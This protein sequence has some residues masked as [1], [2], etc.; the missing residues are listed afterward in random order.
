MNVTAATTAVQQ[1]GFDYLSPERVL[2]M[3]N[4]A[5]DTFE[6]QYE[7]PWLQT[8]I[9][10]P[11]P[12]TV[13]DLKLVQNVRCGDNELMGLSR[14]QVLQGFT[15]LGHA[16]TPEYWWIEG[17]DIVHAWPGDGAELAIVY[18]ADSPELIT[19]TDTPLIPRRYHHL[20]IDYA[21]VEAYKDSDNFTGAQALR[22]DVMLRMQDVIGRYETRNRQHSPFMT[23]RNWH[24]DD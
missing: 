22:G 19:G 12:L 6:D 9:A 15:P 16:G 2:L 13:T 17:D 11:T 14:A 21:V 23:V 24:G 20:W 1:R 7:W 3:L 5:K 4:A 10:G 18:V 8:L